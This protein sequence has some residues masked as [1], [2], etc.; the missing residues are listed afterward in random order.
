MQKTKRKKV[1]KEEKVYIGVYMSVNSFYGWLIS[2]PTIVI[3]FTLLLSR[4]CAIIIERLLLAFVL[5]QVFLILFSLGPVNLA[6]YS[7]FNN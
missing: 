1:Q 3:N 4:G 2:S 6:F 5:S 7:L